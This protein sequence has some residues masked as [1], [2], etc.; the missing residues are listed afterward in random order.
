M[1]KEWQRQVM[2]Y[3]SPHE[4]RDT[5]VW[6]V[7]YRYDP[8]LNGNVMAVRARR[9]GDP[10][11]PVWRMSPQVRMWMDEPRPGLLK[12]IRMWLDK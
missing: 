10:Q 7:Q 3:W 6:A 11:G 4:R 9:M 5:A 8:V 1:L 12:R 2:Y